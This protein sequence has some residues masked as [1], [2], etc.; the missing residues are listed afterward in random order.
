[1]T[2]EIEDYYKNCDVCM[3]H[4]NSQ[5]KAQTKQ[6]PLPTMPMQ[7]L[8]IDMKDMNGRRYIL[9]VYQFTGYIWV[10][11][12]PK[13]TYSSH[14]LRALFMNIFTEITF[15]EEIASEDGG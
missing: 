12:V 6:S 3:K 7:Q 15:P 11:M 14:H 8:C 13:K 1:M 10:D 9:I 2:A 4:Q 5:P